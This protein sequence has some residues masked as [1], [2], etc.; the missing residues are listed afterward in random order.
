M[1]DQQSLQSIEGQDTPKC[2]ECGSNDLA[3][4]DDELYCLKCGLV[5][6]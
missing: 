1:G 5:I 2:P 3:R 6:D 4:R